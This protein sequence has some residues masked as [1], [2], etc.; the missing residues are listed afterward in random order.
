[1]IVTLYVVR[2]IDNDKLYVGITRKTHQ[3][4]WQGHL[5]SASKSS[6]FALHSAIRKHSAS[7]FVCE[8]LARFTSWKEACEAEIAAIDAFQSHISFGRGYNMTHGGDGIVGLSAEAKDRIARAHRRENLSPSTLEAMSLAKRGK[9]LCIETKSKM[10]IAHSGK[11][12][13][14]EHKRKIG[15]ANGE[16]RTAETRKKISKAHSKRV[17]QLS[18][19]GVL[20]AIYPSMIIA[21]RCSGVHASNISRCCLG[22]SM[23]AA[24]Y[25]WSYA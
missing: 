3:K 13:S 9:K 17:V 22:H 2:C 12:F 19:D 15:L 20:I 11:I 8:S 10:S 24:G 1:M 25:V 4:R 5:S 16:N 7:R 6:K 21:A 23:K 18:D 14:E